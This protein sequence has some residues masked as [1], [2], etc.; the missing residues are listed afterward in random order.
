MPVSE[1][2]R[3]SPASVTV[4]RALLIF[5]VGCVAIAPL[6]QFRLIAHMDPGLWNDLYPPWAGTRA[7]LHH[8]DP[9]TPA[10]TAQIQRVMYG[11]V[12]APTD[13]LD[14]QAFVYPAYIAFLLGAFTL[15]P[16]PAVHF[17]FAILAPFALA[18]T[19]WIWMR[20]CQPP[21]DRLTGM[22]AFV[23]IMTSWPAAWG[24]FQRQPSLFVAAAIALSVVFFVRG[25]DI[26]AGI[27]LA[28][29]TVKPQLVILLAVWLLLFALAHRRWRF[30]AAFLLTLA[31]LIGGA[32]MLVPG[33]I[34]HWIHASIAY[35]HYPAKI[36]VLSFLFGRWIGD[37]LV[38]ALIAVVAFRLRRLGPVSA[39]SPGFLSAVALVLAATACVMP[40]NP[41]LLFNN[42]L[43]IP[44]VF[45][46][47]SQRLNGRLPALLQ[48]LAALALFFAFFITPLCAALSLRIGFTL[49]L[50]MPPFVLNYLVA[51]PIMLALLAMP[52]GAL[53]HSRRSAPLV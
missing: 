30:A 43:L 24:Y 9:Y 52:D 2:A 47:F 6:F 20:L 11:H 23:L 37:A 15:L 19:A 14:R 29:A 45:V 22:A 21:F 17:L 35:A 3:P 26:A 36:S 51:I 16:W 41:W 1:D 33:W 25:S 38:L 5:F 4:R 13:P 18:V 39:D 34:P 48:G 27:L 49:N 53:R 44:A 32:Q 7:A 8:I 46:L 50:V 31:L 12:L 42:L 10:M 40:A 28:L